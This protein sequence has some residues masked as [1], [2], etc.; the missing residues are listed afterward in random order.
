MHLWRGYYSITARLSFT[1]RKAEQ[2]QAEA[3]EVAAC[4]LV[5]VRRCMEKADAARQA[6]QECAL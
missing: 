5:A 1:S 3:A 2:E 4:D 6:L